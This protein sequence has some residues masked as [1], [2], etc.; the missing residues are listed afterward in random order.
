MT[1]REPRDLPTSHVVA[2]MLLIGL[3]AL[4]F[5]AALTLVSC[6]AATSVRSGG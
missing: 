4:L 3:I 2:R 1:G 6:V 5:L